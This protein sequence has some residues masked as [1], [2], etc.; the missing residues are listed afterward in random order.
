MA[1]THVG[2][3]PG[4]APAG[5]AAE[6]LRT[7]TIVVYVLYLLAAPCIGL[8]MLIGAVI[9]Y[10]RKNEAKGTAFESHF[11]NAIDVFW[12][13]LVV[14]IV[15]MPLWPLFGLGFFIHAALLVWVLYRTI[16]GLMRA[17]E[18]QPYDH[19]SQV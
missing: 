5:S 9:A 18:W 6:R 1:D 3:S 15:A 11:A 16:K 17:I 12:V 19:Q 10:S 7:F 8:T 2:Y 14:G 4:A 13:S